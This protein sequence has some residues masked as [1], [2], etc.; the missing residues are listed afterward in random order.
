MKESANATE[1]LRKGFVAR[2]L[3]VLQEL[4]F[5]FRWEFTRRHPY[6]LLWWRYATN[7][8]H[9]VGE[10]DH[11]LQQFCPGLLYATLGVCGDPPSPATAYDQLRDQAFLGSWESGAAAPPSVLGLIAVLMKALE[12]SV[13]EQVGNYLINASKVDDE[14]R[15]MAIHRLLFLRDHPFRQRPS[16]VPMLAFN[17][18]APQRQI[19]AAVSKYMQQ[20]K[21]Q[22]G[23]AEHRRRDDKLAT[24]LKVWDLR[25]GWTSSGDYDVT[26]ECTFKEIAKKLRCSVATV[27]GR[28]QCAFR[29]ISGHAYAPDLWLKLFAVKKYFSSA[30]THAR[31]LGRS[32]GRNQAVAS[33][34]PRGRKR[35]VAGAPERPLGLTHQAGKW[36]ADGEFQL[37]LQDL[38]DLVNRGRSDAAI[39]TELGLSV[40]LVFAYRSRRE[41]FESEARTLARRKST[42][43]A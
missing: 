42:R 25:E 26:K 32:I 40:E 20:W 18:Q 39:A 11:A 4:P 27:A 24:Y 1:T 41:E 13:L 14:S 12:P 35:A 29:F 23:I 22:S 15:Q 6:Y 2:P 33:G 38:R 17:V 30:S 36:D 34:K 19:N 37:L 16:N 3:S 43:N 9:A 10:E 5:E 8:F 28:Y 31:P 7:H 21:T